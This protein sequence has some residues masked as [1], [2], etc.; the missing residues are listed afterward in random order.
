MGSST[1]PKHDKEL[2]AIVIHRDIPGKHEDG[3]D[4]WCDPYIIYE[5]DTRT[6][7]EIVEAIVKRDR[8]H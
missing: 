1:K 2:A 7:E 8:R 6:T 4:C 3:L 5:D